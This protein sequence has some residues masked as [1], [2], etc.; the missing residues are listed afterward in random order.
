M[1]ANGMLGECNAPAV[2]IDTCD[3]VDND[4]DGLVDEMLP[5]QCEGSCVNQACNNGTLQNCD[6]SDLPEVEEG[7]NMRA[8]DCDGTVDDNCAGADGCNPMLDLPLPCSLNFGACTEGKRTCQADGTFGPCVRYDGD[9]PELDEAMNEIPVVS[10]NEK[11]EMCNGI[12]DDCDGQTDEGLDPAAIA[13]MDIP[14]SN[15]VGECVPGRLSACTDGVAECEGA[16]LPTEEV[17]DNLDND[18]DGSADEAIQGS[19]DLCDGLD[20]DCDGALDEDAQQDPFET[21]MDGQRQSNDLC[22]EAFNLGTFEQDYPEPRTWS[23]QVTATDVVDHYTVLVEEDSNLCLFGFGNQDYTVTISVIGDD[24]QRF[25]LCTNSA[26]GDAPGLDAVC[27]EFPAAN[28]VEGPGNVVLTREI[29]IEGRCG[30]SDDARVAIRVEGLDVAE[31]RSYQLS[32]LS[33]DR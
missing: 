20:N 1:C 8:D 6:R 9:T 27:G 14:C 21:D 17:C 4:C 23:A 31:C 26:R 10:P 16:T 25:R 30:R 2:A 19:P 3:G 7:G 29:V 12:D 5:A 32:I 13:A 33:Q 28:C 15:D 22:V 11:P 18:C 24:V